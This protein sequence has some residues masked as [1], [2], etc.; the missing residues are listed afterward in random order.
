MA[1]RNVAVTNTLEEFRTTFN[2]LGTDVGDLG[3]LSTTDQ[4]SI[5][6]A[7]N[8]V[9]TS[10][11]TAWTIADDTSTTQKISTGDVFRISG[12]SNQ[13]NATVSA[14]DT[15]TISLASTITGLTSIT[16]NSAT[17]GGITISGSQISSA[18]S[19][20]IQMEA[21]NILNISSASTDTDKFLV[22][23]GGEVK[24]R[25]GS[26]VLSDIGGASTG[27]AIAQAVALG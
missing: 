8:E 1:I 24:S 11:T 2:S 6:A 25:T 3:S 17:I 16:T 27:F 12:T 18:D 9:N 20:V 21:L 13:I 14:T 5:V 15:L 7:I 26:E 19:T 22:S 10:V 23:D 4:S